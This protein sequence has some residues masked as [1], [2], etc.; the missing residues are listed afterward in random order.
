MKLK[1]YGYVLTLEN[2][3]GRN[4]QLIVDE[5][6]IARLTFAHVA[7]DPRWQYLLS[8]FG[9]PILQ[10]NSLYSFRQGVGFNAKLIPTEK[11]KYETLSQNVYI[12]SY[13]PDDEIIP[14]IISYISENFMIVTLSTKEHLENIYNENS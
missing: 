3:Y 5:K 12:P 10:L 11:I 4:K 9:D 6:T 8:Y 7:K 2:D 13:S 1:D 14:K